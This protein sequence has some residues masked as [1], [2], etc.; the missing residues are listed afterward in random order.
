ME[1]ER[2]SGEEGVTPRAKTLLRQIIA[3]G[4]LLVFLFGGLILAGMG[5]CL[6]LEKTEK[7]QVLTTSNLRLAAPLRLSSANRCAR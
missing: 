5:L 3:I 2:N 6:D 7:A 1:S 4:I